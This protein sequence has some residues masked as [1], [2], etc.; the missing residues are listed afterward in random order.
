MGITNSYIYIY[1]YKKNNNKKNKKKSL[2]IA[3]LSSLK[4]FQNRIEL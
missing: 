3:V 1:I 2:E 4:L